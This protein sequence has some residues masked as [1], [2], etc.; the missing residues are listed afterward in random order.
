MTEM[1]QADDKKTGRLDF[2]N[3]K[4]VIQKRVP[5]PEYIRKDEKLLED[6]FMEQQPN[7]R[8]TINYADFATR[9]TQVSYNPFSVSLALITL[10]R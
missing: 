2:K 6:L 4:R 8:G 1:A 9:L 10:V 5:I 7:E 3:F